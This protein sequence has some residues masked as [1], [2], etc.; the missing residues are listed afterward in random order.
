M[1]ILILLYAG[2]HCRSIL[3]KIEDLQIP[4]AFKEFK[5]VLPSVRDLHHLS[6]AHL[7]SS[8]YPQVIDKFRSTCFTSTDEYNISI[9]PKMHILLDHIED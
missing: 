9:A 3:K 1:Q 7:L 4:K 8:N 5:D 6:N 2:P